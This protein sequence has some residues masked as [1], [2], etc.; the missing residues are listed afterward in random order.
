[1]LWGLS[2]GSHGVSQQHHIPDLQHYWHSCV[3][4]NLPFCDSS[5]QLFWCLM[6]DRERQIQTGLCGESM[7]ARSTNLPSPNACWFLPDNSKLT[8][9]PSFILLCF[10]YLCF[11]M[12]QPFSTPLLSIYCRQFHPRGQGDNY[13]GRKTFPK[14][15]RYKD[16]LYLL[17]YFFYL[18]WRFKSSTTKEQR[19]S[20][21]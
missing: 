11:I 18:R 15:I 4:P 6:H 5:L 8:L 12:A 16:L 7:G 20:F 1:M 13:P 21:I 10:I 19:H 14:R 9:F 2:T 3:S 17:T